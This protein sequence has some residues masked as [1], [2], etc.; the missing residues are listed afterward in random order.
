VRIP[1]FLAI[2]A[3]FPPVLF[4]ACSGPSDN[5][6][7]FKQPDATVR[8]VQRHDSPVTIVDV[9]E[10][11][12][13]YSGA[14]CDLPG[15]LIFGANG[16]MT[17]IAG[18]RASPSLTWL[19]LPPGY[20][21]HYFA[22][23]TT[24][25]QIR[26]APG[27]ELF[28]ASPSTATA[29]GA[30]VGY[31]AII[32]LYDDDFDGYADGNTIPDPDAATE[33]PPIFMDDLPSTQGI[34]FAPGYFYFQDSTSIMRL[35]YTKG[36]RTAQGTPEQLADITIYMSSDHWPKTID[37]ADD[38]TIY[39][40][41][42]GDQGESC[43][44]TVFPRPFHGGVLK[45]DGTPGGTP[46]AQGFRNPISIR[47]Q[48]GH[49]LCFSVELAL[50]GSGPEVGREKL[51]PIRAGDDWGYPCCA[52]T[53]TPYENISGTPNCANVPAESVAFIVG[54]T[55]F[56]FDFE[57]GLW[58][59]P[60]TSNVLMALHG[61]VGSWQGA[62]VVAVPTQAN[63]LPVTSSDLTGSLPP[64]VNFATGWDD[65]MHDHGRPAAA[66]FGADGRLYIANDITGDI[67]WIAPVTLNAPPHDAGVTDA[68]VEASSP[69]GEAGA[70]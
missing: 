39:A 8:D 59:A 65:G 11:D 43:D 16:A 36:E 15:S 9:T 33:S 61:Y 69:D 66:T 45:I 57:T 52:T 31:G 60:F 53:N 23:V 20:C 2:A 64:T 30:P 38:G 7:P 35:P 68:T 56:G 21:A 47:C 27:G 32:A 37:I 62:R 24:A 55:P 54:E 41:N 46:V 28:V 19:T 44:P 26:V 51:V 17:L 5:P 1:L 29:G 12:G 34:A 6:P 13:T 63:G 50:D 67:F 58:P 25:R 49:N 4:G 18:G 14:F 10:V 22:N 42:G 48:H 40:G 70:D 3:A